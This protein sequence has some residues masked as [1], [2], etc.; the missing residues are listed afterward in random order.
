MITQ[1]RLKEV[2][3]YNPDTGLFTRL[4]RTAYCTKVGDIAGT[5]DGNGYI[6]IRI[7]YKQYPAHRLA[8]L[9][10][11]GKWPE[12]DTDHAD[13]VRSN[14]K[15]TNLRDATR[16]QNCENQKKAHINNK[17]S[18]LLGAYP[19]GKG[20]YAMIQIKGKRKYIGTFETKELAHEAYLNAKRELHEFNTL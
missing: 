5:L 7:D 17:S 1:E 11:T 4:V 13:G 14:N 8:F 16:S 12:N 2:L 3:N 10:M 6:A 18:G 9:Y 19:N 15:W 20:F